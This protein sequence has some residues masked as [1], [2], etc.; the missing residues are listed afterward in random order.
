MKF[1]DIDFEKCGKGAVVIYQNIGGEGF[2]EVFGRRSER[3]FGSCA[4]KRRLN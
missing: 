2:M 1:V 4:G 3:F